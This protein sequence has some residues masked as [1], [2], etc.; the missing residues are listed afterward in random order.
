MTQPHTICVAPTGVFTAFDSTC[1]A[2]LK[3]ARLRAAPSETRRP[4]GAPSADRE[5]IF[6]DHGQTIAHQM[7]QQIG[8][9]E[10][11]RQRHPEMMARGPRRVGDPLQEARGQLLARGGLVADRADDF[12]GDTGAEPV[13]QQRHHQRR[14]HLQACLQIAAHLL[15]G[16][17]I[18]REQIGH[19]QRRRDAFGDAGGVIGAFGNEGRD[20]RDLRLQRTIDV[21]LDQHGPRL[22]MIS[23]TALRRAGPMVAVVGFCCVGT[24]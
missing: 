17:E 2:W 8:A 7:R 10:M 21:V 15:L 24:R 19:P 12:V 23:A 22:R 3:S 18:G 1:S 11:R 20:R 13:R 5:R 6:A 4:R 16:G 14:R 9:G